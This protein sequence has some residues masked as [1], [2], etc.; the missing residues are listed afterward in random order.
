MPPRSTPCAPSRCKTARPISWT[1]S[2]ENGDSG[3]RIAQFLDRVTA[4]L[5]E[6][7]ATR[8][9]FEESHWPERAASHVAATA[10]AQASAAPA[11]SVPRPLTLLP[12]PE[13]IG[14][15]ALVPDYPPRKFVW[16]RCH[17]KIARAEGPERISPEWWPARRRRPPR[18]IITGWRTKRASASGFT[19]S[20]IHDRP[21]EQRWFL[22]GL[23][24]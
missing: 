14:V 5:G 22:H 11:L 8:F 13:P 6:K 15:I 3:E 24:A 16:R 23:F 12:R 7:A 2:R 10:A 19:G 20:G 9:A 1:A 21:E 18:A 4:R 17:H